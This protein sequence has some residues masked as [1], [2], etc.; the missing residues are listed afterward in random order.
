MFVPRLQSTL[1]A[2]LLSLAA[3]A[4]PA[5]APAPAAASQTFQGSGGGAIINTVPSPEGVTLT[6]RVV[7]QATQIG[8]FTRT[9]TLLLNPQTGDFTGEAV[10]TARDGDQLRALVVGRFVLPNTAA[11][12]YTFDGGTGRFRNALGTAGFVVVS[13]DGVNFDVLFRGSLLRRR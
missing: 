10:F 4:L 5:A 6:T 11:G 13:E 9:E 7:G 8:R 3:F 2:L 1:S 12:S